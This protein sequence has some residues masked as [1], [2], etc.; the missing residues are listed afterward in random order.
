[1]NFT[2]HGPK[3]LSASGKRYVGSD[4]SRSISSCCMDVRLELAFLQRNISSSF[5][6]KRFTRVRTQE[7]VIWSGGV[8]LDLTYSFDL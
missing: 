8:H 7:G 3:P 6:Q 1:M 5:L 4:G 2:A